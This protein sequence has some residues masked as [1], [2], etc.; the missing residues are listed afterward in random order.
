MEAAK[1]GAK[2]LSE[3]DPTMHQS[4][5]SCL[6]ELITTNSQLHDEPA[7]LFKAHLSERVTSMESNVDI[8]YCDTG[9]LSSVSRS[10]S[11]LN[12]SSLIRKSYNQVNLLI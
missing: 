4:S 9:L 3:P 5:R 10:S 12:R 1:N 7:Q 11:T 6:T 8:A 2:A